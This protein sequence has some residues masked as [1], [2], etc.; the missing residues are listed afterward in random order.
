MLVCE[1]CAYV[2][3]ELGKRKRE[4]NTRHDIGK[5]Q[6]KLE[7]YKPFNRQRNKGYNTMAH[8]T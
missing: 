8:E 4:R 5:R 1:V 6:K 2:W 7:K 3:W